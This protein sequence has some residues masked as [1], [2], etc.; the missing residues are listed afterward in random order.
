MSLTERR[1]T[2]A[3]VLKD[4]KVLLARRANG[5]KNVGY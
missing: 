1:V 2:A 4:K 5:Q 3:I